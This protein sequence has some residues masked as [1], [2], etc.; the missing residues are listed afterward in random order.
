MCGSVPALGPVDVVLPPRGLALEIPA[1]IKGRDH[2]P[3]AAFR[4]IGEKGEK[5]AYSKYGRKRRMILGWIF[6]SLQK[7]QKPASEFCS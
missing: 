6:P 1:V 4:K 3:G 2:P 7:K 5:G